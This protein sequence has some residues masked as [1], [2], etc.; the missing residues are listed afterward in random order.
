MV[1]GIATPKL[2]DDWDE[3]NIKKNKLN[4]KTMNL[5]YYALDPDEFNRVSMCHHDSLLCS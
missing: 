5:L 2:E 3:Q 4:A 1:H